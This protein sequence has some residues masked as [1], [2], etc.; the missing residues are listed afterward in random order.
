MEW[1]ELAFH[2]KPFGSVYVFCYVHMYFDGYKTYIVK[3]SSY[4]LA[5][6]SHMTTMHSLTD[7]LQRLTFLRNRGIIFSIV[8]LLSCV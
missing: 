6:V 4:L 2:Y 7:I 5:R 3:N 1:G 8:D